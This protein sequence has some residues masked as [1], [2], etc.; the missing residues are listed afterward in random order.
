MSWSKQILNQLPG[1]Q[2]EGRQWTDD[3]LIHYLTTLNVEQ[4]MALT[5]FLWPDLV[6]YKG[7]VILADRFR[8]DNFEEW[9]RVLGGDLTAIEATMNHFHLQDVRLR[10]GGTFKEGAEEIPFELLDE[11]GRVIAQMLECR[12]RHCYPD[13]SFNVHYEHLLDEE[14]I[15]ITFWQRRRDL[16]WDHGGKS[17]DF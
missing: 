13:K 17:V 10:F 3:P 11:W 6:E 9:F 5:S 8:E 15:I 2:K 1:Y 12:L 16:E 14:N 7:C 4:A